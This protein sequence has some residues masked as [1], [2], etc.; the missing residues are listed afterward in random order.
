MVRTR[1]IPVESEDHLFCH[2]LTH[3]H[4]HANMH[5]H[6]HTLLQTAIWTVIYSSSKVNHATGYLGQKK[7]CVCPEY[8]VC[9][10][11]GSTAET[12]WVCVRVCASVWEEEVLGVPRLPS[13]CC[14]KILSYTT[15]YSNLTLLC[16]RKN[17]GW[18]ISSLPVLPKNKQMVAS[19][20]F[21]T[22]KIKTSGTQFFTAFL[23]MFRFRQKSTKITIW[24]FKT[25]KFEGH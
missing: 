25:Q 7:T 19:L 12:G 21:T 1:S 13:C 2:T 4:T 9:V 3:I 6:T 22:T 16:E 11:G 23:R 8:S 15:K 10:G 14:Y 18:S 20:Y 17:T 24:M 5:T